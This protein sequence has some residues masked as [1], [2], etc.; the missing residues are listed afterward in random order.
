MYVPDT[1]KVFTI[2]SLNC[3][4]YLGKDNGWMIIGE[5]ED[6]ELELFATALCIKLIV[7]MPQDSGVQINIE[8]ER[9]MPAILC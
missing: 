5:F 4:F 2:A 7:N 6:G 1:N 9:K 8:D 3:P